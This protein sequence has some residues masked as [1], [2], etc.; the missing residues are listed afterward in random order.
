MKKVFIAMVLFSAFAG[1]ARAASLSGR[2]SSA[3][4]F[5]ERTF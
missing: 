4:L 3:Q 5:L 2:Q 1:N